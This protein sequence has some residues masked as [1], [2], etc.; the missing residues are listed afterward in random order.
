MQLK[1]T[2]TVSI[3]LALWLCWL[4]CCLHAAH[5]TECAQKVQWCVRLQLRSNG[6]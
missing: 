1:E 3:T 5:N 6:P 2:G 4:E